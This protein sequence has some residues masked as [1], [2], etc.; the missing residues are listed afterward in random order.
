MGEPEP[1][2]HAPKITRRTLS[3]A[4]YVCAKCKRRGG[5]LKKENGNYV[6]YPWCGTVKSEGR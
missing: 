2:P 4:V 5:T 6:C 3:D 1:S